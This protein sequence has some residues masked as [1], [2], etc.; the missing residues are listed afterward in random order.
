[1]RTAFFTHPY[2]ALVHWSFLATFIGHTNFAVV[3]SLF[4]RYFMGF[5]GWPARLAESVW[6]MPLLAL[7]T[8]VACTPLLYPLIIYPIPDAP[9]IKELFR[10]QLPH[11]QEYESKMSYACVPN[12]D[13]SRFFILIVIVLFV[14]FLIMGIVLYGI[15]LHRIY[16]TNPHDALFRTTTRLHNM[17]VKAFGVQL[18]VGYVFLCLPCMAMF[19]AFYAQW[20]EGTTICAFSF[21]MLQL[22]GSAD[23]VTMMYFITPYR[24]KLMEILWR[25]PLSMI[26]VD[27]AEWLAKYTLPITA[28]IEVTCAPYVIFLALFHSRQMKRYRFLILN[29]VVGSCLLNLAFCLAKPHYMFPAACVINDSTL[30]RNHYSNV[31]YN[32]VFVL[33]L[34]YSDM[35]IVWSLFYRYFIAFPGWP[36]DFVDK[37][38]LALFLAVGGQVLMS[39]VVLFPLLVFPIPSPLTQKSLFLQQL[40]QLKG[41]EPYLSYVCIAHSETATSYALLRLIILIGFFATGTTLFCIMSYKLAVLKSSRGYFG[42]TQKMHRMLYKAVAV[43]LFIGYIFF[44]F[45]TAVAMLTYYCQWKEGTTIASICTMLVQF[46]GCVDLL[47]MMYFITPYRQK[48]MKMMTGKRAEETKFTTTI[49]VAYSSSRF[50]NKGSANSCTLLS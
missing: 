24:K 44:L 23:F 18:F 7:L 22:H 46:H 32:C 30:L 6:F 26:Y 3:W 11:L 29:N 36:S 48:F 35:S 28:L 50:T 27:G 13:A 31:A 49:T 40:P 1:M 25:N 41:Q 38:N 45:P 10:Q 16:I 2:V 15:M 20:E 39:A 47:T 34:L 21:A 12:S 33:L 8:Y 14:T 37:G 43:Q 42:S 9:R 4:Y 5:F 19:A 17:L